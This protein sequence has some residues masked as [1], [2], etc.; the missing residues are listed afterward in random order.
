MNVLD[1][2]ICKH[3]P[4]IVLKAMSLEDYA[5]YF[6]LDIAPILGVNPFKKR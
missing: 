6:L 3:K 1:R 4:V 2:A 5:I